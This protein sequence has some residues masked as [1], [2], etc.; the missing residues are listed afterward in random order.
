MLGKRL[1]SVY[2]QENGYVEVDIDIGANS[3]AAHI[4]S[5]VAGAIKSLVF[6]IGIVIEVRSPRCAYRGLFDGSLDRRQ[7]RGGFSQQI[8]VLCMIHD[9]V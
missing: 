7:R 8:I 3:T 2:Y 5:L 6:D 4:T 9:L 1:K